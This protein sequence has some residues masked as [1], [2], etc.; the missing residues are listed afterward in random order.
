MVCIN[1]KARRIEISLAK[2]RRQAADCC[3]YCGCHALWAKSHTAWNWPDSSVCP[4]CRGEAVAK[5][6]VASRR[7]TRTF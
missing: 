6:W 1:P 5:N 7:A 2:S 3:P 4:V